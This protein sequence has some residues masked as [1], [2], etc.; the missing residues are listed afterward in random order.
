MLATELN[1]N[2]LHACVKAEGGK[3]LD[4]LKGISFELEKC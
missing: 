2:V 1:P 4:E 3:R